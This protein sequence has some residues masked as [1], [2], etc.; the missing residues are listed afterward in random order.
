ME[1][2]T[3]IVF[4]GDSFTDRTGVK[5]ACNPEKR[6]STHY[7]GNYAEYVMKRLFIHYP[8][9]DFRFYNLGISGD[10]VAEVTDR[11]CSTIP[12]IE[13]DILVLLVGHNDVKKITY[14]EF[15]NQYSCLVKKINDA[16]IKL[17]G[18]S[19]L[20]VRDK[21]ELNEVV[22]QF[23]DGIKMILEKYGNQ[24]LDMYQYFHTVNK[25]NKKIKLYEETNHLS[26]LGNLYIGDAVFATISKL[27]Y[28]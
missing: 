18:I 23:N 7:A 11:Y 28:K 12:G 20:P 6:F 13:P 3:K 9:F 15:I 8:E 14:E 24:Y 10:T 22:E 26:E 1:K 19:I 16:G 27:I 17:V 5:N 21:V 2:E 4:L 25:G